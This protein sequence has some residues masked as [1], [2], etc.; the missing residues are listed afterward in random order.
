MLFT[1]T[2]G[3]PDPAQGCSLSPLALDQELVNWPLVLWENSHAHLFTWC[4]GALIGWVQQGLYSLFGPL[5]LN[6]LVF[7]PLRKSLLFPGLY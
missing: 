5:S 1:E 7:A 2:H 6:Y 4:L 3:G